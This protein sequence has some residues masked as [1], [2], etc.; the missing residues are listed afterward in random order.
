MFSIFDVNAGCGRR[1]RGWGLVTC[2]QM[3]KGEEV[4]NGHF[5]GRPLWTAFNEQLCIWE[6]EKHIAC[7]VRGQTE[8]EVW[9]CTAGSCL[10]LDLGKSRT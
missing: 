7:S 6:V 9:D 4:E 10:P 2:G 8:T 3:W 1:Q 5:Y